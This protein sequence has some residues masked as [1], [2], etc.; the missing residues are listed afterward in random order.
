MVSKVG[1]KQLSVVLYC[2]SQ[3]YYSSKQKSH[4][5]LWNDE[6]CRC[7]KVIFCK[8]WSEFKIHTDVNLAHMLINA[9]SPHGL[10]A[11]CRFWGCKWSGGWSDGAASE[12]E[13]NVE[14]VGHELNPNRTYIS[15]WPWIKDRHDGLKQTN[16]IVGVWQGNT[17]VSTT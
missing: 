5:L 6:A 8:T 11:T 3:K 13:F 16:R 2:D 10:R 1:A 14:N 17:V 12:V 9:V 15:F 7:C 4:T